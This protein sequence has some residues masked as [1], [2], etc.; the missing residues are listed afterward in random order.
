MLVFSP[1]IICISRKKEIE[2]RL[3]KT[4]MCIYKYIHEYINHMFYNKHV[5]C[6]YYM[7]WGFT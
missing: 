6:F 5:Q 1:Y 7:F 3:L 4:Y 2:Y